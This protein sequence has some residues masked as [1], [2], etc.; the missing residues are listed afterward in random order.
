M[1]QLNEDVL[2]HIVT[3]LSPETLDRVNVA[4]SVFFDAWMK[5]RY[6]SLILVKSDK[7]LLAHLV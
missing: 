1:G 3:Y 2:R 7:R 5:S 4:N 6:E